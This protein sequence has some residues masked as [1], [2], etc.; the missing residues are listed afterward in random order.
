MH[1]GKSKMFG[2]A[3]RVANYEA[4]IRDYSF[5][6]WTAKAM[7]LKDLRTPQETKIWG[8]ISELILGFLFFIFWK[9]LNGLKP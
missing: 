1:T 6:M 3:L 9:A 2:L 7:D 5:Y 4:I 8:M